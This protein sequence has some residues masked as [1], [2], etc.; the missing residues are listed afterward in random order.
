MALFGTTAYDRTR[1]LSAAVKARRRGRRK[2]A[3]ELY[4]RVLDVEPENVDLLRK[5]AAL[6]AESG[7]SDE[8]WGAYRRAVDGI[9]AKGFLERSI[10]VL[11]EAAAYLPR[12]IEVW[13]RLADLELQRSRPADAHRVLLEGRR[14]FRAGRDI[15]EA[16][17]LLLRAR[18]IVPGHFDTDYDLAR[19]FARAGARPRAQTILEQLV[20]HSTRRQLRKLR[21][22]QFAISPSPA[23][24]WRWLRALF[25]R[26]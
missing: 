2:K 13:Q 5:V 18:R 6:H 22:R 3:I 14:H 21:A 23:S 12:Q 11:R 16:I 20:P 26:A 4:R 9:A 8:A 10:G 15:R 19:L 17:L 7:Q 24:G 1:I 25:G